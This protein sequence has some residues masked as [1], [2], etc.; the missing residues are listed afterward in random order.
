VSLTVDASGKMTGSKLFGPFGEQ[1]R[2][3]TPPKE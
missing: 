1:D 2:P 3:L